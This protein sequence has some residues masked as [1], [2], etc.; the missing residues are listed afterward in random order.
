MRALKCSPARY[1]IH[2]VV[3]LFDRAVFQFA[4]QVTEQHRFVDEQF[5]RVFA[6]SLRNAA[7]KLLGGGFDR[8]VLSYFV[9]HVVDLRNFL[10]RNGWFFPF[11]Y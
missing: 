2:V 3:E 10:A 1:G 11:Q 6:V 8:L 4:V 7:H 9:S 5:A